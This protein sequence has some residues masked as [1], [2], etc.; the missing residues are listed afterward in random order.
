MII[1]QPEELAR[2]NPFPSPPSKKEFQNF[3]CP[4]GIN[5]IARVGGGRK[6]LKVIPG[7]VLPAAGERE[8]TFIRNYRSTSTSQKR[9]REN[10]IHVTCNIISRIDDQAYSLHDPR[11]CGD[12][13]ATWAERYDLGRR[14]SKRWYLTGISDQIDTC[15]G[16]SVLGS[17]LASTLSIAWRLASISITPF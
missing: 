1:M 15:G 11:C 13:S 2:T 7:N 14:A 8:T 9:I 4:R 5:L 10:C 17:K 16:R 3:I 12:A 6:L